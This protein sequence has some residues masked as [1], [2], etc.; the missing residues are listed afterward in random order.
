MVKSMSKNHSFAQRAHSFLQQLI[1]YIHQP[2]EPQERNT[3]NAVLPGSLFHTR[4]M[5]T[6]PRETAE[7]TN[8]SADLD[9]LFGFA[10]ELTEN[11]ETQL[12][13][14]DSQGLSESMWTFS[15]ETSFDGFS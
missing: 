3:E 1:E 10:Q 8:V 13:N 2:P 12:G 11:L 7:T 6:Q 14:F 9:A 4:F 5:E 15:E